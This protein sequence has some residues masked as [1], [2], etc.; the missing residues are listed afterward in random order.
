MRENS[1][2]MTHLEEIKKQH[3]KYAIS[4]RDHEDE[5]NQMDRKCN[6]AK[7]QLTES[8]A[9]ERELSRKISLLEQSVYQHNDELYHLR[10]TKE[11][12]TFENNELKNQVVVL[13]GKG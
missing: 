5:I 11:T 8:I 9:R 3:E 4:F 13:Q 6:E 2:L 10:Q 1:I 7:K 12:L